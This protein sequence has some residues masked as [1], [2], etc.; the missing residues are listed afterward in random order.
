[1]AGQVAVVAHA[2]V[3]VAIPYDPFRVGLRGGVRAKGGQQVA[4]GPVAR[5]TK[6]LG[7]ALRVH[8]KVA[9]RVYEAGEEHAFLQMDFLAP[10]PGGERAEFFQRADGENFPF[11]DANGFGCGFSLVHSK[12]FR[13]GDKRA[14]VCEHNHFLFKPMRR[15]AG[16]AARGREGPYHPTGLVR[17]YGRRYHCFCPTSFRANMAAMPITVIAP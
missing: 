6:K 4:D 12:Y 5:I 10:M 9:V 7:A 16:R 1:M 17:R 8:G 15:R 11:T 2:C 14:F 3:V 13:A